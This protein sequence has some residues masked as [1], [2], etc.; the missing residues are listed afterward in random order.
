MLKV[1]ELSFSYHSSRTILHQIDFD[2]EE[3]R[4]IAVLGNNGA[5]KSTLIKCLNRI[6][7]PK[8]GFVY[9]DGQDMQSLKRNNI[10]RCMAYVAQRN[11]G[12]RFTVFDSVLL[13][14]KPYIKMEPSQEDLDI[15]SSVIKRM[16][17]EEFALRDAGPSTGSAT[18]GIASR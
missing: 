15:T 2:V 13:G 1:K 14:R 16:G 8:E 12:D 6:L 4:C 3:G 17:L 9:V 10:A 7:E 11:A 18:P 5:G